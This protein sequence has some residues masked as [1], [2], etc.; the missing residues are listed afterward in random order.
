M[1]WVHFLI[2]ASNWWQGQA[3]VVGWWWATYKRQYLSWLSVQSVGEFFVIRDDVSHIDVA[4]V[5]LDKHI[6]PDLIPTPNISAVRGRP[7]ILYTC[8]GR[9]R[10]FQIGE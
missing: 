1:R 2:A 9:R 10:R 6:L 8:R 7:D 4:I 5:L 3:L